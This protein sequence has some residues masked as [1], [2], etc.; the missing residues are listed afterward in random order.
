MEIPKRNSW[1]IAEN[2]TLKEGSSPPEQRAQALVLFCGRLM[3]TLFYEGAIR[4]CRVCAAESVPFEAVA[5]ASNYHFEVTDAFRTNLNAQRRNSKFQVPSNEE[6]RKL[7]SDRLRLLFR[8]K[9]AAGRD[10]A[11][12]YFFGESLERS[13]HVW[14]GTLI[15]AKREHGHG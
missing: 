15:G 14:N 9:M 7:I 4:M 12:M 13:G 3:E 8:Q 1:K 2:R 6:G 5:K 10:R 11:A